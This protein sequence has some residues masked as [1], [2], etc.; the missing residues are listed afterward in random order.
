MQ[1]YIIR[2]LVLLI[3][4]TL[5][6]TITVFFSLRLIPGDLVVSIV[7]QQPFITDAEK[8]IQELRHEMG[9]DVPI[10]VQYLHWIKN[11]LRGN[12]GNSLFSKEPVVDDIVARLPVSI[13]LGLIGL[14]IGQLVAIPLGVISAI[15]QDTIVDYI[16]RISAISL[17]CVPGF[18]LGTLIMVYPSRWWGWSP[19]MEYIPFLQDPIKNLSMFIIPGLVIGLSSAGGTMRLTR[20]MMLDVLRQDY[21][22]TAW[23]KGLAEKRIVIRHALKNALI[24][25]ITV[26]GMGIPVLIGGTV[27]IEQIF[28]LPGMGRLLLS[29]LT[30]KD[31]TLVSGIN[32]CI[33]VFVLVVNLAVDLSYGFLNPRIRYK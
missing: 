11:L 20:S 1:A 29:S 23:A 21:I 10:H 14:I 17:M 32:L 8:A 12:L 19:S 27:I 2:R 16:G 13:E 30:T 15:R 33:A 9:L 31:F 25:V 28:N 6:I 4:T 24:P 18:W 26:I 3:I 5:I 7:A 22:R